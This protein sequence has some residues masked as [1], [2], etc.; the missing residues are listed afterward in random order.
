MRSIRRSIVRDI[1]EE[2]AL[3]K[4][5]RVQI[6]FSPAEIAQIKLFMSERLGDIESWP[7]NIVLCRWATQMLDSMG[8]D[9]KS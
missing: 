8:D 3:G 2:S 9:I 5:I 4:R 1:G 6:D 7:I